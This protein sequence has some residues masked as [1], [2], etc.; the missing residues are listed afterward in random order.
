MKEK[1]KKSIVNEVIMTQLCLIKSVIVILSPV[2]SLLVL[3]IILDYFTEDTIWVLTILLTI[4]FVLYGLL[5]CVNYL[6]KKQ[7][8]LIESKHPI[9]K[10]ILGVITLYMVLLG[11]GFNLDQ[12]TNFT[13]SLNIN[14][15]SLLVS[16]SYG[17]IL[18]ILNYEESKLA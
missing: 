1:N 16:S 11:T 3:M 18:I 5:K 15:I 14:V 8:V 13:T 10:L 6:F 4:N 7:W 9:V 2:V 17:F 12:D